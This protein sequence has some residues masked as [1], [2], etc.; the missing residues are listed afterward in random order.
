MHDWAGSYY[1][2]GGYG[3]GPE[4]WMIAALAIAAPFIIMALVWSVFWKGLALWH[5]AQRGQPWWFVIM[6]FVNTL[7]ILEIIYL[8]F[9]AKVKLNE[10]FT[11]NTHTHTHHTHRHTS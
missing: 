7:G 5:S 4:G 1:G 10:L 9:V 11:C 8:F 3:F 6:L 2:N